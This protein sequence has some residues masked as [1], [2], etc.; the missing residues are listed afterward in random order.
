LF[1]VDAAYAAHMETKV[2]TLQPGMWADFILISHD[3][4]KVSEQAIDDI[5]VLSTYVA[6]K[7]VVPASRTAAAR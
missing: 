6:G 4:F 7:P 2:G 3:Y 5:R 1:T